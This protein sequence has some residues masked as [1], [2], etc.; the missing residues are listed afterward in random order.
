MLRPL[1]THSLEPESAVQNSLVIS[2]DAFH[3]CSHG[4]NILKKELQTTVS[5]AQE[6][7]RRLPEAHGLHHV[8]ERG[9]QD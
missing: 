3:N 4:P 9:Q 8:A 6:E 5:K 7:N 1:Q 2:L